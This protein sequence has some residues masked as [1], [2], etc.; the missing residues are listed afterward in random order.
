MSAL[1]KF[2]N[3]FVPQEDDGYTEDSFKPEQPSNASQ[4]YGNN[5][6]PRDPRTVEN[7]NVMVQ[8]TPAARSISSTNVSAAN[9]AIE[10][11]VV[12]PEKFEM[13]GEVANLLLDGNTVLLNL[14]DTNKE[15][16]RRLI[17]FLTGV[18]Y[19]ISGDLKKIANSTYV[20]T[21]NNVT[22]SDADKSDDTISE[23]G[24]IY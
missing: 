11:K 4:N 13:V 3:I 19:A 12:K 8:R 14:E 15:T 1:D 9:S 20:I 6:I 18:A 7:N 5:N 16:S 17:D 10:M 2:I 24:E 22:V 23:T 21:P